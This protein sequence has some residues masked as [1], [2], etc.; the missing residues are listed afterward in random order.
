MVFFEHIHTEEDYAR[1]QFVAKYAGSLGIHG[2]GIE[3]AKTLPEFEQRSWVKTRP[4]YSINHNSRAAALKLQLCMHVLRTSEK[5]LVPSEC[6][7][8]AR[9][10]YSHSSSSYVPVLVLPPALPYVVIRLYAQ[11][12]ALRVF[13][14]YNYALFLASEGARARPCFNLIAARRV[15]LLTNPTAARDAQLTSERPGNISGNIQNFWL[16]NG[17]LDGTV[18]FLT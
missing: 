2:D 16:R 14:K 4:L 18:E 13:S 10:P 6:Y 17:I 1:P 9:L 3:A 5:P 12:G 8:Q 7:H 15:M 11:D